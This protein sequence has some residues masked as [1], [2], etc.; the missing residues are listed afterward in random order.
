MTC[1]R[2][3]QPRSTSRSRLYPRAMSSAE[4]LGSEQRSRYLLSRF[5]STLMAGGV[6]PEQAA[7][8]DAQVPVQAGLV[9]MTPRSSARLVLVSLSLPEIISSS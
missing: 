4:S 6:D 2:S 5:S 8:G 1:L 9:K 7:G 3:C